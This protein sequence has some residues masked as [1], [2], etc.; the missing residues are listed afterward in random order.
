M[1]HWAHIDATK[2]NFKNASLIMHFHRIAEQC[3]RYICH[4]FSYFV[5]FHFISF[6][7]VSGFIF[8]YSMEYCRYFVFISF[9]SVAQTHAHIDHTC[10]KNKKRIK[11]Q[12]KLSW[13]VDFTRVF[14]IFVF[15]LFRIDGTYWIDHF[16]HW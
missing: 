4:H 3:D 2:R 7:F 14:W 12:K 5:L 9:H 8:Q 15:F 6:C 1:S 16:H 13:F 11:N 10:I